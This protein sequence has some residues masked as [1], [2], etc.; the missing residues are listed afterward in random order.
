M[1]HFIIVNCRVNSTFIVVILSD[2]NV[3]TEHSS[4]EMN[5]IF[6]HAAKHIPDPPFSSYSIWVQLK[7]LSHS[8]V[9]K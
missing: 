4:S 6:T 9:K 3:M 7:N 5:R 8:H 1:R 2:L